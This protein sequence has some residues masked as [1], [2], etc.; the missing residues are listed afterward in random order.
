ML[1]HLVNPQSVLPIG[2]TYKQMVQ[3]KNIAKEQGFLDK[4]ILLVENGQ[5]VIFTPGGVVLGKKIHLKSVYVDAISGE[6]VETFVLRD[7]QKLATDGVVIVM[8]EINAETGQLYNKPNIIVR[9]F[10][11]PEAGQITI[12][13]AR[14]LKNATSLKRR[15]VTDWIYM[16]KFVGEVAE[17]YIF[18]NLRKRPL[19][20]PVVIEV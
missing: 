7:R 13:L 5:P 16:R 15:P 2:G 1:M 9:G 11:V 19:I 10:S 6:E 8:A 3:Y 14:Q 20:L 18:K 12:D 4:N 17:K